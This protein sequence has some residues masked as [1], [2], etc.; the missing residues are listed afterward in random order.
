M[1]PYRILCL[2]SALFVLLVAFGAAAETARATVSTVG[3][4]PGRHVLFVEG[5]DADGH[6]RVPT[7]VFLRVVSVLQTFI[8]PWS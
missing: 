6:W 1:I 8:C 2:A 7:A 3:L 5:Q 4:P